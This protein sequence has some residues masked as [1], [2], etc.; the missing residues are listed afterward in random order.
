[1]DKYYQSKLEEMI[2]QKDLNMQMVFQA[3]DTYI[4]E[5]KRIEKDSIIKINDKYEIKIYNLIGC[6]LSFYI[7]S[8]FFSFFVKPITFNLYF[9]EKDSYE[10]DIISMPQLKHITQKY[11]FNLLLI[12]C[13]KDKQYFEITYENLKQHEKHKNDCLKESIYLNKLSNQDFNLFFKER[14]DF[15]NK[16]LKPL[17]FEPNFKLYFNNCE[18]ILEENELFFLEDKFQKRIKINDL[19]N[20]ENTCDSL[21]HFFGQPGNGK[22][23]TLIGFLKYKINHSDIGTFYINCKAFHSLEKS[24]QIKQLIIDEIPFLFYENYNDYYECAKAIIDFNYEKGSSF[25]VLIKLVIE[26]LINMKKKKSY[27]ILVF[28]QY[29]DNIDNNH[30]ELDNLYDKLIRNKNQKIK[31]SHFS[32]LTFSSMNNK[33]IRE[34]KIRYIKNNLNKEN[35]KGHR[36]CEIDNLEYNI[37]LDNGGKYDKSLQ[38]LGYGLKYYNILRYYKKYDKEY[39]VF[40]LMNKTK[41]HIRKNL[42]NFFQI[43]GD[44]LSPSNLNILCSFSTGVYYSEK[45]LLQT[46]DKIPFK[47]FDIKKDIFTN[48]YMIIF[49]F[50]LVGE[51]INKIYSDIIKTN[52]NIYSNLTE[53]EFDEGAKEKFFEKI[54]TY[55][56]NKESSIYQ[57]KK[58]IDFFKDY[59]ILYHKEIEVLVLNNNEQLEEIENKKILGKGVTLITQKRYNGK[60]LDIALIKI[61]DINELIGIQISI[62]KKEIFTEKDISDYLSNLKSNVENNF[63]V[64]I[65]EKS[66]YFCYIFE[67]NKI[68][69]SMIRKCKKNKMKYFFFDVINKNFV[70]EHNREIISLKP[71]LLN[72]P[73][74]PSYNREKKVKKRMFYTIEECFGLKN[75]TDTKE[76]ESKNEQNFLGLIKKGQY[77]AINDKQEQS[78]KHIFQNIFARTS[79]EP[80]LEYLFSKDCFAK[81]FLTSESDFCISKYEGTD[82][83]LNNSIIITTYLNENY[84]IKDNGEISS[85]KFN[86]TNA[87]DY[88]TYS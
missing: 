9:N 27:Y 17:E 81:R 24:I 33:D 19:I 85:Y 60:A 78:I 48:K 13:S 53:L 77:C 75:P 71:Y 66:L 7:Q 57:D 41:S 28:D 23:L 51:V 8:E 47:Y 49:S 10:I 72:V 84:L 20:I 67:N 76:D 50:P 46:L 11:N 43:D 32:I 73:M 82:N 45:E 59:P 39:E 5:G 54:I 62:H 86:I 37:S 42:L 52:P 31:D 83:S 29:N 4:K 18:I 55:Y 1:M 26:K 64:E 30:K 34:Y 88:Y 87:Y 61:G 56:L 2:I 80:K 63:D 35:D 40:V 21:I 69:S 22:T 15:F 12:Y 38:K 58:Q 68:D 65:D 16:T 25:F 70:S 3:I 44:I 79:F 74:I 14:F 36:L 6:S